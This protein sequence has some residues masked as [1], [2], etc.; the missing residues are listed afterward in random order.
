M[1]VCMYDLRTANK[2]N[3]SP[4]VT[5]THVASVCQV[6][7]TRIPTYAVCHSA[8]RVY[9][10]FYKK[11]HQTARPPLDNPSC[12]LSKEEES[13]SFMRKSSFITKNLKHFI[14]ILSV[15]SVND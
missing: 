7:A 4:V 14:F 15:P 9:R 12:S 8:L 1:Y 13:S 6:Q 5:S 2:S 3:T 11:H 10:L